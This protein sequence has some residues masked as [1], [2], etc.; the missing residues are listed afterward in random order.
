MTKELKG[1]TH[2]AQLNNWEDSCGAAP[3][4]ERF[5]EKEI[6]KSNIPIM[7][8][9]GNGKAPCPRDVLEL[10]NGVYPSTPV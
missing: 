8:G 4:Q 9:R 3:E 2:N 7:E 5:L 6:T 10:E 1:I